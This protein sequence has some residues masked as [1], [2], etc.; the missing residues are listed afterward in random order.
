MSADSQR[1]HPIFSA[2][3]DA[4]PRQQPRTLLRSAT[5]SG[6]TLH[7]LGLSPV[8]GAEG[9]LRSGESDPECALVMETLSFRVRQG[10]VIADEML[11]RAQNH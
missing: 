10:I 4:G 2:F 6:H 3:L 9:L 1:G 8:A 5:R 7:A 11:Q